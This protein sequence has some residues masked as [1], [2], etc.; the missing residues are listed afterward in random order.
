MSFQNGLNAESERYGHGIKYISVKDILN[1]DFIT[2]ERIEGLVDATEKERETFKVSYGDILFQRSS[3]VPLDIGRSNVY[4]DNV[5]CLFGG[6]VIRGHKE[7]S[8]D[9]Y[10]L[11]T[12]L[13]SSVNRKNIIRLGAGAQH[14]NIGQESIRSVVT[15]LPSLE[16][17]TKISNFFRLLNERIE[18]Q[19]KII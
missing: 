2:Y 10:F 16:E 17:Q 1:G 7:S 6:F 11:K 12:A 13:E 14:Y 8:Y 3:E 15:N 19:N 4:L 5:P 9:P 18:T